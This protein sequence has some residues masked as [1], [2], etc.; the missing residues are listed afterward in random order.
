M[1]LP[2]FLKRKNAGI[3]TGWR[4]IVG[5]LGA[6]LIMTGFIVLI[7][8]VMMILFPNE[9]AAWPAFLV[10]GLSAIAIGFAA[11]YFCLA[12]AEKGQ[13]GR[14]QDSLLLCLLWLM[15]LLVGAFPFF[16][17]GHFVPG[18]YKYTYFESMF[19]ATSGFTTTGLTVFRHF[20][21][22]YMDASGEWHDIGI[23]TDG[24]E[25]ARSIAINCPHIFIFYRSVLHFFGGVGLVLIAA[26]AISDAHG[27]KLYTA[28]GHNDKLLPN[29]KKSS[30]LI[31]TIY[32]G[33]IGAGTIALWFFGMDWFD[34]LQHSV[35]SLATGGLSSRS[36]SLY[37]FI[38]PEN[39]ASYK[40]AYQ[41]I[42]S[43]CAFSSISG[44]NGIMPINTMGME[45]TAVILMLLGATNFLIHTKLFTAKFKQFFR[46]CEIRLVIALVCIGVPLMMIG[47]LSQWSGEGNITFGAA[48]RYSVF[49]FV[50]C[51]TTTGFSNV[52]TILYLGPSVLFLSVVTM[53]IG[54]GMGSTA[55][56]LKQYRAA[57]CLKEVWWEIKY[58]L[59]PRRMLNP[60]PFYRFGERRQLSD[61]EFKDISMY[62]IVYVTSILIGA[63]LVALLP[64]VTFDQAIYEVSSALSSAGNSMIDFLDYS[65]VAVEESRVWS[66]NLLLV[67]C[68]V[69]MY[70]GRLE[71]LPV[72]YAAS[73][74]VHPSR[75]STHTGG[76]VVYVD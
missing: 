3:A 17:H 2:S 8:F 13:L 76:E 38:N 44:Y 37:Y 48:F 59:S 56:G 62:S 47:T 26:S 1:K 19:E 34:A 39:I 51:L 61:S 6:F 45:I 28:E 70:L 29:L 57:L 35:A 10:T 25:V 52:K 27:L 54:G 64:T 50:S 14:H 46:D 9:T 31:L 33:Y 60:K 71:I 66:Y 73:S 18:A 5:Y 63:T 24:A 21:D 15:A 67:I 11:Y 30:R 55:G 22:R 75:G 41:G 69:Y 36:T 68:I 40:E 72:F 42:S 65:R 74:I 58:H 16:L 32:A 53:S 23:G 43:G 7:P 49:Q 12:G 20:L 4:L